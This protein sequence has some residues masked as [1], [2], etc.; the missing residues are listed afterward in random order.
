MPRIVQV[1][2]SHK[3][4]L[5]THQIAQAIGSCRSD[6]KEALKMMQYITS[7]GRVLVVNDKWR[8]EMSAD[9]IPRDKPKF[10]FRYIKEMI[11]VIENL[12]EDFISIEEVVSLN[13]GEKSEIEQS[14]SFIAKITQNGQISSSGNLLSQKW[15]LTPWESLDKTEN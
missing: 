2:N 3:Q 5:P 6:A 12:P 10:R 4:P 11:Q 9:M 15:T 1:F 8:R 7:F 13:N 14:L